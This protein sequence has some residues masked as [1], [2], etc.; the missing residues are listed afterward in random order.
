[1]PLT[2]V[3]L[4]AGAAGLAAAEAARAQEPGCRVVLLSEDARLPYYRTRLCELLGDPSRAELLT[5]HPREWYE[6]RGLELR[7]GCRVLRLRPDARALDIEGG[8]TLNYDRLILCSGIAPIIPQVPGSDLDGVESIWTM[9]DALRV[10][11]RAWPPARTSPPSSRDRMAAP[12]ACGWRT[13]A[14]SPRISS[15]SAPWRRAAGTACG[16]SRDR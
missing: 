15:F 9:D 16:A 6:A 3:I 8:A 13:A 7:L 10:E 14:S 2:I 4:G 12:R 1:M 5:I 11:K